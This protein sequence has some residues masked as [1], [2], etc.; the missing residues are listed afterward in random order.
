MPEKNRNLLNSME[1]MKAD[2]KR[3]KEQVKQVNL[4]IDLKALKKEF[5]LDGMLACAILLGVDMI[6]WAIISQF[7]EPIEPIVIM[8]S[9]VAV[10]I[11]DYV[12]MEEVWNDYNKKKDIL[13]KSEIDERKSQGFG[14]YYL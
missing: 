4:K 14:N 3:V 9:G 10:G 8:I 5:I 11:L 2:I 12:Y 1:E 7:V 13:S 6:M